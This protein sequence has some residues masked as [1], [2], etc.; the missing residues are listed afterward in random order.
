MAKTITRKLLL[1]FGSTGPTAKFAQFG[2]LAAGAPLNSKDLLTIQSLTAWLN[3]LQDALYGA[4]KAPLME[5][6]NGLFYVLAYQACYMLQ[7]GVPEWDS[8]TTYYTGSIVRGPGTGAYYVSLVDTNLNQSLPA[9]GMDNA[10]WQSG[11][12]TPAARIGNGLT[13]AQISGMSSSKL[14]GLILDA[15]ISGMNVSKLIGTILDA[16]IN[17]M[18]ATKLIG[19]IQDAQINTV[20][21][22]KITGAVGFNG[23]TTFPILQIKYFTTNTPSTIFSAGYLDTNLSGSITP[24]QASSKILVRAGGTV[25]Q[26]VGGG[27]L[28]T[29]ARNGANIAPTANGFFSTVSNNNYCV[30]METYD[31]PNTTSPVTYS[32]QAKTTGAGSIGFPPDLGG[33]NGAACQ[34]ILTEIGN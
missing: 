25:A 27:G 17:G 33:S 31:S 7:E 8:T 2:S 1:P 15:Q 13:D 4:N 20:S 19:L 22:T 16:N 3:G 34:L 29:I 10:N 11:I 21:G 24:K 23:F 30:A 5:D 14:I 12:T 32:V 18:S 26:N 6:I 9:A 28:V